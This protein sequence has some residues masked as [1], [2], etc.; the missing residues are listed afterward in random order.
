MNSSDSETD[1]ELQ[2]VSYNGV[3]YS[4]IEFESYDSIDKVTKKNLY[5]IREMEKD[6]Y[7]TV[8]FTSKDD[9]KEKMINDFLNVKYEIEYPNQENQE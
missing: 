2:T 4:K 3:N 6:I 1:F 5:L 8:A 7:Y 9:V